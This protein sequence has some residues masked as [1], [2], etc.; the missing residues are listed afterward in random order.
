M[1]RAEKIVQIYDALCE[2]IEEKPTIDKISISD[3][4]CKLDMGKSTIYEYFDSK[5]SLVFNAT[6]YMMEKFL[7]ELYQIEFIDFEDCTLNFLNAFYKFQKK[8]KKI[9]LSLY[10]NIFFENENIKNDYQ[11]QVFKTRDIAH[12]IGVKILNLGIEQKKFNKTAINPFN[13]IFME[14]MIVQMMNV[15][16][17]K[18]EI[19]NMDLNA[20]SKQLYKTILNFLQVKTETI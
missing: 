1:D 3:I 7:D 2:L 17:T 8:A 13:I 9:C 18:K 14:T 6:K 5:E 12:E 16:E 20:Y 11:I 4:A 15:Y 19:L 10:T